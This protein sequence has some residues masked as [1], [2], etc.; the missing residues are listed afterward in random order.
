MAFLL[1]LWEKEQLI[2][3]VQKS[4]DEERM[5]SAITREELVSRVETADRHIDEGRCV[6][7]ADAI[8]QFT[9]K[10]NQKRAAL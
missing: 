3:D 6:S 1:P 9:A 5:S 10:I 4:I 2:K 7:H 8:A